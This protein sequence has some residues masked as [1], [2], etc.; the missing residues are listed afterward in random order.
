M[1]LSWTRGRVFRRARKGKDLQVNDLEV[2]ISVPSHFRCP[3]TLDLMKDP[4]T[5]STGI[6]YDRDSIE[7]WIE[8]GNNTCPVTKRVLTTFDM[9]PNHALRRMIQDWCVE[10][11]SFGIERIPTPR[12]PVTPYEVS[13]TCTKIVNAAKQGDEN[14][15]REL[16]RK[17][18]GWEKE[19]D[20]NKRCIVANGASLALVNAFDFFSSWGFEENN[21][22]SSLLEEIL[23]VLAWMRPIGEEGKSMLGS[24]NS[25][26]C[27]VWFL[28]KGNID[29]SIKQSVAMLL[30]EVPIE[31]L[32]N[33][34]G[35]AEGLVK[36]I[37]EPI[38]SASITKACLSMIFKLVTYSK[39]KDVISQR[40]VELG[41]VEVLLETIVDC[42]KGVCEKAL[43]VLDSICG[44]KE[45]KEIAKANALTIPLVV[46]KL[47][48]VSE[49][50][51]SFAVSIVWKICDKAQEE[52]GVFV[53][54]L[55]VGV[56][57]K[58]LVLLQ[59]GCGES[60]KEKATELLKLLNGYRSKVDCV[61][62]SLEFQHLK[63]PF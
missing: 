24:K 62:T 45:G 49:L 33:T 32:A 36:M 57:Q 6:T 58:L 60:T 17:I 25:M 15:C 29:L 27:M 51:S 9:I 41:L 3:V 10:H 61:D 30:K 2:E 16:V 4:V 20:R 28:L 31:V 52:E 13:D 22:V 39:G 55:Q 7:K 19:S 46:K 14:K 47:L 21:N 37:K 42:D 8:E 18:K 50:S 26:S 23:G 53:E 40:F 1:V 5:V 48:R 38:G 11:R 44:T 54:A 43:G 56:F 59:V 63:K 34:Q 35:V 12:I